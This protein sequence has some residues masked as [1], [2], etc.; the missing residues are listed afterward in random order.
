M[1]RCKMILLGALTGI[2]LPCSSAAQELD[3]QELIRRVETQYNGESSYAIMTMSIVTEEPQSL[4]SLA[5]ML[6]Q[7]L[8]D[9]SDLN[10]ALPN[11]FRIPRGTVVKVFTDDPGT[12]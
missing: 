5:A 1:K 9:L 6:G 8:E 10:P 3:P 7:R 2:L 12:G 11:P 4:A